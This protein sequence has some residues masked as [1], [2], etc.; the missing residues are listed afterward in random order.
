MDSSSEISRVAEKVNDMVA[1][2]KVAVWSLISGDGVNDPEVAELMHR[3]CGKR[4]LKLEG[5][6]FD[7]FLDWANKSMRAVSQSSPGEKV[8]G[9]A[10]PASI[11]IDDLM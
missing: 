6:D 7:G 8:K 3:F 5:Y 4:V 10:L 9:Q 2:E 11:T 1:A